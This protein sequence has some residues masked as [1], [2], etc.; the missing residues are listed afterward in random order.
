MAHRRPR[1]RGLAGILEVY[2]SGPVMSPRDPKCIVV[3]GNGSWLLAG[4]AV[5]AGE[6]FGRAARHRSVTQEPR[7]V[8]PHHQHVHFKVALGL[9]PL[10]P[11]AGQEHEEHSTGSYEPG[12][13]AAASSLQLSA[14][15]QYS[16]P[17]PRLT[18]GVLENEI[19]ILADTSQHGVFD[20]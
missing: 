20:L 1:P 5:P 6:R 15:C 13:K 12:P 19:T 10:Q 7:L 2:F 17:R 4:M 11:E 18:E 8:Q 9:C 14:P 16:V 3:P